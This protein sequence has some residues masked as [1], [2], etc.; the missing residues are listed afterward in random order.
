M[1]AVAD[2]ECRELHR[3]VALHKGLLIDREQ[4]LTVLKSGE[5]GGRH[6]E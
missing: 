6:V 4:Q 2:V 5:D 1:L 3:Q